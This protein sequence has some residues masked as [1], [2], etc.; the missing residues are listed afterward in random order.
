MKISL[1]FKHAA[2]AAL[3]FTSYAHAA[4]LEV[5]NCWIRSMPANLPSS[6]YFVVANNGDQPATLTDVQTPAFGMAMLHR[7]ESNGS[8]STMSHVASAEVPAHGTLAFA[9]S[10]YH[11]MLEDAPKPLKIGSTIPLTLTFSDH[12]SVA[13]TCTV[14]P[15][16]A[17]GN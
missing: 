9:P 1:A 2:L 15:P 3:V 5:R 12:S 14:K 17:L 10:G 16:S 13:A 11:V 6:G 8:T 7:S 4:T